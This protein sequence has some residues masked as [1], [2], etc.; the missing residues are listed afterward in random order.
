MN[1]PIYDG[2]PIWN[3]NSV[4]FGFYNQYTDFQIDC[5]KVAEFVTIR[6]GYPLVDIELQSGSIFTAFEEAIT[7]YGNELYAYLVRDNLLSLEGLKIEDFVFLNNSIITPNLSSVIRIAEEYGSEAG[8]GGNVT[9]YMGKVPLTSSVQ[10]YDLKKWA[11]EQEPPITGSIEIKRVFFEDPIPAS[12]RYLEPFHG[13]GFGGVAAAGLFELGGFGGGMGYLMMPLNY[14]LQVIQQIEMNTQIRL[15]NYS[16]EMH[17]NVLRVFPVPG[18][19]PGS[20]R[21]TLEGE[22]SG[23][24]C[25]N[26]WFEYIKVDDRISGS[27]DPACGKASNASNLPYTNPNYDLINSIGRQWIF[28]YTLA[29]CKEILG[30]IRGKYSTLPIPNADMT[31]NQADLLASATAD[32]TAL[33][34]RLRT[35]FDETSRAA[36]LAR[37]AEEEENINR[38]LEGVPNYIYIG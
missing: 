3:P 30:Y 24:F 9:W 8:T 1:V 10:D 2:Q 32:K 5:V 25:G 7:T 29:L 15:S 6:L 35:Y 12:A 14:D 19:S 23:T 27:V 21:A 38:T 28:E 26:M 17:N 22:S 34:E 16:F 11:K 36:L 18:T 31:L 20:N 37:K 13:F 33:L 4:P